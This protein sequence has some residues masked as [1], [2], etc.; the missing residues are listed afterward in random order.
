M[1]TPIATNLY[2]RRS[3]R[4]AETA[5][6]ATANH[7][8]SHTHD[9]HILHTVAEHSRP[10]QCPDPDYFLSLLSKASPFSSAKSLESGSHT[11]EYCRTSDSTRAHSWERG[12][13]HDDCAPGHGDSVYQEVLI[14]Q[15]SLTDCTGCF[16]LV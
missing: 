10:Q 1:E 9:H 2:I 11:Q 15:D 16:P 12:Q 6:G 14:I 8:S 13:S 4:S 3:T 7:K 5:R